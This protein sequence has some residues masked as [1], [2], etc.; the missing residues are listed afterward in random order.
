VEKFNIGG[1]CAS[2][3]TPIYGQVILASPRCGLDEKWLFLWINRW[4]SFPDSLHRQSGFF[5]EKK[6]NIQ[7]E[8]QDP[9]HLYGCFVV[10]HTIPIPYYDYYS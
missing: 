10:I 9:S 8:S 1:K 7:P 5:L 6:P 4:I 3:P 2:P